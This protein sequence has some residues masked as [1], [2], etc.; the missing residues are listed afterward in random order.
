MVWLLLRSPEARAE[1]LL[2]ATGISRN[3]I[4]WELLKN[5]KLPKPSTNLER[6]IVALTTQ[7]DKAERL[8]EQYRYDAR[9]SLES[10]LQLNSE[11]ALEILRA[12]KPPK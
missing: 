2:L 7:A 12:F 5:L 8:A 9:E 1:M 6:K 11:G 3:R 10:P 4:K